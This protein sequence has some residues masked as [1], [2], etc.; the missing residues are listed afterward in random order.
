MVHPDQ[1]TTLAAWASAPHSAGER[2]AIVIAA[3]RVLEAAH[4]KGR[5]HRDFKPD[6]VLVAADGAVE[7][8]GFG[9]TGGTPAYQAPAQHEG[10]DADARGDQFAFAV[11][12]WEVLYGARPFRGATAR[13]LT[14]AIVEGRV[15]PPPAEHD[16]P[17]AIER[18]LRRALAVNPRNRYL[19]LTALVDALAH[20]IAPAAPV[21]SRRQ[22]WLWTLAVIVA[23]IAGA[24]AIAIAINRR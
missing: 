22:R 1:R 6:H 13:A 5:L 14:A 20:A 16:V 2:I 8:V 11:S 7:V 3:G 24:V 17:R 21:G 15:T 12:A 19:D 18:V 10:A 9:Q 23:I 4:R